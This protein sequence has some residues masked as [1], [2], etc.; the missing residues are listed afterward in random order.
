MER[1]HERVAW[2]ATGASQPGDG[3]RVWRYMKLDGFA[4]LVQTGELHMTRLDALERLDADEGRWLEGT[5]DLQFT[6]GGGNPAVLVAALEAERYRTS[7]SCWTLRLHEQAHMWEKFN[8]DVAV[9]ALYEDLV[10]AGPGVAIGGVSYLGTLREFVQR[11]G[12]VNTCNLAFAKRPGF[13]KEQEVRL[14][15][16]H[17]GDSPPPPAARLRINLQRL[18]PTVFAQPECIDAVKGLLADA[19][20]EGVEI[21]RR[22]TCDGGPSRTR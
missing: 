2:R 7:V 19:G 14:V 4:D 16:Q 10:S 9:A 15:Y 21:H 11:F 3:V 18:R 13:K 6:P 1:E 22:G 5:D 12:R 17:E 20:L 8:A